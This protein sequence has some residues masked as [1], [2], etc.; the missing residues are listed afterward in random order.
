MAPARKDAEKLRKHINTAKRAQITALHDAKLTPTEISHQLEVNRRTVSRIIK[1][2]VSGNST[3]R[4]VGSGRP[5]ITSERTDSRIKRTITNDRFLS[6]NDLR[7]MLDLKELSLNTI[8]RRIHSTTNF[9]SYWAMRKPFINAVNAQKRLDFAHEH[10]DKPLSFW[11]NILW[12]DESPFTLVSQ[13]RE[14]CWRLPH[15]RYELY[16]MTA[17]VKHDKKINVWGCFTGHGVGD[18]YHIEGIMTADDYVNIINTQ[19]LPSAEIL[20]GDGEWIFQ[21]DNDPKHTAKVSQKCLEDNG[22]K[23]LQW[24]PQSPDLNPI[25]NL[26]ALLNLKLKER[27]PTKEAELFELLRKEWLSFDTD[28]LQRY[29]DSMSRRL[30]AVI[31]NNGFQTKY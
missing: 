8:Y 6:G 30:E 10:K 31:A 26:W 15:E 13:R 12:S 20:F 28:L 17:N 4:K 24:P 29:T 1:K 21:Q 16:C 23:V 5:K 2:H 18:L 19:L 25:E 7:V 14:R 9:K 27:R 22:V 3:A 11:R